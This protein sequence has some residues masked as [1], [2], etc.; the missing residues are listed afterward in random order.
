MID[1]L[2]AQKQL[3]V[4]DNM[5]FNSL[6]KVDNYC[7]KDNTND[8]EI[9]C[10]TKVMDAHTLLARYLRSY[11]LPHQYQNDECYF[12]PLNKIISSSSY[13]FIN[14]KHGLCEHHRQDFYVFLINHVHMYSKNY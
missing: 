10:Y 5:V 9:E 3:E 7:I 6:I 1:R 14:I 4:F 13:K 11:M 8:T 12:V 2:V